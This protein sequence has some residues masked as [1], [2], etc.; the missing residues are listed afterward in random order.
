MGKIF[1]RVLIITFLIP[2][3]FSLKDKRQVIKSLITKIQQ[4]FNV[5]IIEA[6]YQEQWQ[7]TQI[8]IAF[9]GNQLSFLDSLQQEMLKFIEEEYPIEITEIAVNDF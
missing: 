2:S 6:A 7:L 5:S 9:I 8:G 3:A 4:R 1:G